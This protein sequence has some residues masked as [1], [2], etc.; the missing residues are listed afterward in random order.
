M[1]SPTG[2]GV[3]VGDEIAIAPIRGSGYGV[4]LCVGVGVVTGIGVIRPNSLFLLSADVIK[5]PPIAAKINAATAVAAPDTRRLM[6]AQPTGQ[7]SVKI[8]PSARR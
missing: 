1:N 5:I 8:V 7:S 4:G 3:G 2:V 6:R